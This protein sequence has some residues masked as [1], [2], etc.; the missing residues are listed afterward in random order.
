MLRS[1][2]ART[3]TRRLNELRNMGR[4]DGAPDDV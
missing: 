3:L 4:S 1:G 2:K